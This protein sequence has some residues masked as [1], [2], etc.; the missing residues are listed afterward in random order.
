MAIQSCQII[1][2]SCSLMSRSSFCEDL[3][4]LL[5]VGHST[6]YVGTSDCQFTA[7]YKQHGHIPWGKIVEHPDH[8]IEKQSRPESDH[9][10][11]EPSWMTEHGVN[12]WLKHWVMR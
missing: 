6:N 3:S 11:R 5:G 10:L 1:R 4:G 8:F 12:V 2:W 7:F 9:I